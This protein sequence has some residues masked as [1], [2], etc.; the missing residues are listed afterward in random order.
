M[1]VGNRWKSIC[2]DLLQALK[3]LALCGMVEFP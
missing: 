1:L 2:G 3:S